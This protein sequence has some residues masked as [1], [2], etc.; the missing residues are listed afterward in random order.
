MDD[1]LSRWG[2][3]QSRI[4]HCGECCEKWP[5]DVTRP[6]GRS[7]NADGTAPDHALRVVTTRD[8]PCR[9][10]IARAGK[11]IPLPEGIGPLFCLGDEKPGKFR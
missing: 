7:E 4:A 3:I 8:I 5:K 10:V 2:K 6:V 1:R 11:M 9:P